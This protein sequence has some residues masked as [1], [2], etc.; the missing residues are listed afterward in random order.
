MFV[1][2]DNLTTFWIY[3]Y[4][5][6]LQAN[7]N[8]GLRKVLGAYKATPIRNLEL[9]AFWPP[10]EL[11]FNKPLVD[12]ETRLKE[13]GMGVKIEQACRKIKGKLRNRRGRPRIPNPIPNYGIWA[14]IW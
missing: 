4:P 3:I 14:T 6:S 11:Y 8:A 13:A 1:K 5:N 10:L 2:P 12:F 9:E 7:Q